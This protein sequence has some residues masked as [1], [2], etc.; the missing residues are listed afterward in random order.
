M[1]GFDKMK[2][3]LAGYLVLQ[4]AAA[5]ILMI[6]SLPP[7]FAQTPGSSLAA[8]YSAN[9]DKPIDIEADALEVDDLKKVA[10]F[11]GNVSATQGDFN[12]RAKEILVTYTSEKGQKP[13]GANDTA[14]GPGG[15]SQIK[16]IDATG[17]VL[18]TTKDNQTATSD[19][20]KFDVV[21]QQV[22]IGGN[23]VLS[24]GLN[25][26]KGD[27]LVIDLKTGLSRFENSQ[28]I[29]A[30][31]EQPKQRLRAIFTPKSRPDVKN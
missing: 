2:N 31:G 6:A 25:T 20:A 15:D 10:I 5:S 26:I 11:K 17:K 16:Q 12:L 7:A 24:Q 4:T 3:R 27:R 22:T 13:E 1:T 28:E 18:V 14:A 19:W 29:T 9:S 23:V 21:G 8:N 30:G